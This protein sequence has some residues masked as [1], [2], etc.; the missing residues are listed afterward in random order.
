MSFRGKAVKE[1]RAADT[2]EIRLRATRGSVGG[3]PGGPW[4]RERDA[5]RVSDSGAA[6]V[7]TCPVATGLVV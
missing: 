5:V 7:I 1:T 6:F 4:C 3:V 2:H